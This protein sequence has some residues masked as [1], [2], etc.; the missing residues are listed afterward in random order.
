MHRSKVRISLALAGWLGCMPL[1]QADLG[2]S[3]VQ[4]AVRPPS[5]A[6]R[7]VIPNDSSSLRQG[8]VTALAPGGDRVEI[9]G[10]WHRID[11]TRSRFVRDGRVVRS[12]ALQKG[13]ALRYTLL[14]GQGESSTL[15]IVYVP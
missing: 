9:Q 2:G 3:A 1:A 14:A 15:G 13:Q 11:P 10:Q 8:V 4:P 7:A 6:P 5:D 12:D